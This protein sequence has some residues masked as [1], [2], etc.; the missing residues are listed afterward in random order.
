MR[1]GVDVGGTHTDAVILDG[2]DLVA[3]TKALTSDDIS[4]GVLAAVKEV[5]AQSGVAAGDINMITIGTTQFTNAIVE[6]RELSPVAAIRIG[7]QSSSALPFAAKWPG[8]I[9]ERILGHTVMVDGGHEYDGSPIVPLDGAALD[10][11]IADLKSLG[12]DAV[13]ITSVFSTSNTETELAVAEKV[14]AALP[15]ATISL[16]HKLG[17][18]GIYQRENATLLNAGLRALASKVVAAFETAFRDLELT[19]PLFMS[20]NDG[21]LM[22]AEY[23]RQFPVFTFSSGPTNSMRGATFLT[24]AKSAM[25]V[26]VG[27]TTSDIGMLVDGFP[28]PS[29]AA[30]KVG[31]V[32]TNFR[33]PDVL[34]IG[35]GG[36]TRISADGQE[37][38]PQSVGRDLPTKGQVFG[39]D[40]LTATDIA[41]AAGRAEIGDAGKVRS[42]LHEAVIAAAMEGM[43]DKLENGIDIMKTNPEDLPLIVVGGGGFLVPDDL[44]GVSEVMRPANAGVAN[45]IGAAFAQVSGE[46]DMIYSASLRPRETALEEARDMACA[47]AVSAGAIE[48]SVEVVEVEETP[49]SYMAEPGAVIRVKAVGDVDLAKFAQSGRAL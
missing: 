5:L 1:I 47:R 15:D 46:A 45:A 40:V 30:V 18:I 37:I 9:A 16:S 49:M 6:R 25:V 10:L 19:C 4:S 11:A 12:P 32:L 14:A 13:A 41:V 38:G 21:T 34:A 27:G 24:G 7:A 2:Q 42:V 31:G 36:G 33:M 29:G 35:L 39:G 8:D 48:S 43:R 20:Q 23:A 26:D 44:A 28:R 3:A 22:S 17:R